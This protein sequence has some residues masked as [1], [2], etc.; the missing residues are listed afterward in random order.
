MT[1]LF[2]K[3][4]RQKAKARIALCAPSGGGKTHSALL[5]AAGLGKKIALVD[6]E[7]G[8]AEME[9]GK[10]GIPEYD[11]LVLSAPF[12][13]KKYISAIKMAEQANY[14][15]IIID[16]LSHAWAGSGGA[17]DI[18][19]QILQASKTQNSWTAWRAITPLHNALI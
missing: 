17:L 5:I 19:E 8:S 11:V 12:E 6:T 10:P 18:K 13:P 1:N 14:D 7:N 4:E 2:R 3:A 15:V 16:S 9:Q